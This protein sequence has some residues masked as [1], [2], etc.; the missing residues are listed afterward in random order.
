[1]KLR[2]AHPGKF[3][4]GAAMLP[5]AFAA[6]LSVMSPNGWTQSMAKPP[7]SKGADAA[8]SVVVPPVVDPSMSKQAPAI[9]D[10][11]AVKPPPMNVDPDAVRKPHPKA[12]P[13]KALEKGKESAGKQ[14]PRNSAASAS[15]VPRNGQGGQSVSAGP[16]A[17]DDCKGA[18]ELCKQDSAR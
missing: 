17:R 6:F 1:M 8:G 16:S 12:N 11:P 5:A 4:R 13:D 9:L 15:S 7:E 3:K 10:S 2:A 14:G 18:A